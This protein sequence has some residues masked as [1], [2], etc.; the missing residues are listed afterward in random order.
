MK[1]L[2][3]KMFKNYLNDCGLDWRFWDC[4]E[5]AE[6][7]VCWLA[8]HDYKISRRFADWPVETRSRIVSSTVFC[9]RWNAPIE[10]K[11]EGEWRVLHRI[12]HGC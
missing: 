2:C 9:A 1:K 7:M 12:L 10:K 5:A 11:S 4:V 6:L 8:A 3:Q